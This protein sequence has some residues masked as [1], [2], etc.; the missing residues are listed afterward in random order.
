MKVFNDLK[1]HDCSDILIAVPDSATI[2]LVWLRPSPFKPNSRHMLEHIE[3]LR[4][5]QRL[6]LPED[7]DRQ[8][9]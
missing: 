2:W 5:Y 1:T 8:I 9:H 7:I 6:A 4:T 3:R